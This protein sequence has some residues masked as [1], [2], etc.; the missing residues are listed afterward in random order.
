MLHKCQSRRKSSKAEPLVG[1]FISWLAFQLLLCHE[2]GAAAAESLGSAGARRTRASKGVQRA[3]SC[4]WIAV[5]GPGGMGEHVDLK[6]K[7]TE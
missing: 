3:F 5:P 7:W 1:N 6:D 4:Q 2:E